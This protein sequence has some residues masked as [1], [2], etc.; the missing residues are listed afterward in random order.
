MT[1]GYVATTVVFFV[2]T[3]LITLGVYYHYTKVSIKSIPVVSVVFQ[4]IALYVCILPF[5]LLVVDVEAALSGNEQH[6][7]RPIWLTIFA[8][9]YI[10][11]WITLPIVQMLTIVGDFTWQ[12]RLK[13]SVILNLKLY[14]V[15]IVLI[16]LVFFFILFLKGALHSLK[17]VVKIGLALANSWGL[18]MLLIFMPAGLVGVPRML[19]K[20]ADPRKLLRRRLFESVDIQ[21]DLDLA[22]MDLAAIKSELMTIDPL[23]SEENRPHLSEMLEAISVAD[24]DIPLYHIAAQRVKVKPSENRDD[25]SLEHLVALNARL[26]RSIVVVGRANYRWNKTVK[27]CHSLD[28]MIRGVKET[29]NSFK[30][31][32]FSVRTYVYWF[33]CITCG[34]LTILILWSELTLPFRQMAG[35]PLGLVEVIMGSSIHFVASIVFLFYMAYCAYWAAFQFKVFDI[36][37]VYPSIADNA[38]LCFN[39]VFLVRL[40]MPLC[41][42]FLLISNL[43]TADNVDVQ[44]GYVYRRNMDIGELFGTVANQYLPMVIPFLAIVVLLNL[45][46]RILSLVG[47]EVHNPNDVESP[48]V[49]QRIED[50]RKLVEHALGFELVSVVLPGEEPYVPGQTPSRV[51]RGESPR[52]S[53]VK[54]GRYREYK[55]KQ[56][57]P[58][59]EGMEE[60]TV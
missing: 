41:F 40:L 18:F 39:M 60:G 47:I 25:V 36:Y 30:K 49:R 53:A 5:P 37:V 54:G 15:I 42:N 16:V 33:G 9:T 7:M 3:F 4:I 52:A 24:R 26:K 31:V 12:K 19:Y 45:T 57:G 20:Y 2:L 35:V 43:S 29:N 58:E 28:E 8:T 48:P 22:S 10:S 50:G 51:N 23:V 21:D 27:D 14:A 55:D 34:F 38:S 32:W 44:Y 17:S 11:A 1:A 59:P 46:Q 13:S 56:K 6:W